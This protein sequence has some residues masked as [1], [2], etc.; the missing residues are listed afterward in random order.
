MHGLVD[1]A[2]ANNSVHPV[3][4]DEFWTALRR[5][6]ESQALVETGRLIRDL[7]DVDPEDTLSYARQCFLIARTS[8][9]KPLHESGCLG[10]W[11]LQHLG[12]G[13]WNVRHVGSFLL[14]CPGRCFC[15]TSLPTSYIPTPPEA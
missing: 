6:P 13:T 14:L 1:Q 5:A 8:T 9:S 15:S 3:E 11:G 10:C 7:P 2:L 4:A 12:F